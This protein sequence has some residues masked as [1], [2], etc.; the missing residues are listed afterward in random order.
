MRPIDA[1]AL[2]DD[3]KRDSKK[4]I[5]DGDKVGSFW[6]GY[7]AGLVI[8]EPTIQPEPTDEQVA[9]Y[10]KRRCLYVVTDDFFRVAQPERTEGEWVLKDY[11]WE[12]N[13][14]GCRINVKNPLC[15]NNWNYYFCPH[16]GTKMTIAVQRF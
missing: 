15:D 13:K 10:C 1:N 8:K 6:L 11:L 16:C 4:A 5:D 14:C 3:I 2:M 12:C 7:A 9:E